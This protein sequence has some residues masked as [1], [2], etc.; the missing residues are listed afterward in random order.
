MPF[1]LTWLCWMWEVS[2]RFY[3]IISTCRFLFAGVFTI[4]PSHQTSVGI[5]FYGTPMFCLIHPIIC[6]HSV[7]ISPEFKRERAVNTL[8]SL[9][10][11]SFP[12]DRTRVMPFPLTWLCWMWE[13]SHRFYFIISTCR[14]LFAGVFTITP[15][16]QTSVGI[17]FYGTPMFCLIH[18]IICTHSVVISPE[19]KRERAVN[20]LCSFAAFLF[21]TDRTIVMPFCLWEVSQSISS[22][23]TS[24]MSAMEFWVSFRFPPSFS[25]SSCF[26]KVGFSLLSATIY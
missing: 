26:N 2:H 8:C 25:F 13:V 10:A 24:G 4:T 18:P 7:V 23:L 22:I 14:F 5:S 15:S 1:P 16:H 21:P 11:F 6:T 9:A 19:F 17:S 12:T 20:T 3:F